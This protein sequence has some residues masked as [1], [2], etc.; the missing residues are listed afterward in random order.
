MTALLIV[1]LLFVVLYFF[2]DDGSDGPEGYA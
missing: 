2:T 1:A